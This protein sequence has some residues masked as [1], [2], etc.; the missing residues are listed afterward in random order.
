MAAKPNPKKP[1]KPVGR[2]EAE[3]EHLGEVK[4]EIGAE[5]FEDEKEKIIDMISEMFNANKNNS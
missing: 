4:L 3:F 5:L 1:K 2:P